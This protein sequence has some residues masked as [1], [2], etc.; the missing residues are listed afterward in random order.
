MA[1]SAGAKGLSGDVGRPG[2]PGLTGARVNLDGGLS[3]ILTACLM[4][5]NLTEYLETF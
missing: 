4:N 3:N 1:G 2:E 5:S